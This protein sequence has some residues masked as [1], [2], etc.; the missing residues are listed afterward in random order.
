MA[1]ST[2]RRSL[3]TPW[4]LA[5]ALAVTAVVVVLGWSK[6]AVASAWEPS[7]TLEGGVG[8]DTWTGNAGVYWTLTAVRAPEGYYY[9][10]TVSE[11]V[12]TP[13]P[14]TGGG[15][16]LP[17]ITLR[18]SLPRGTVATIATIVVTVRFALGGGA[19]K[20][21]TAS[22]SVSLPFCPK[23]DRATVAFFM[24]CDRSVDVTITY[25][26]SG[27]V[28]TSAAVY[29]QS[30]SG[31]RWESGEL[32]LRAFGDVVT[33]RVPSPYTTRV[34]VTQV[35]GLI[36][37]ENAY[38]AHAWELAQPANCSSNPTSAP[39]PTTGG[40][41][42]GGPGGAAT[43]GGG[44]GGGTTGGG[45]SSIGPTGLPSTDGGSA[46]TSQA[47]PAVGASGAAGREAKRPSPPT[48]SPASVPMSLAAVAGVGALTGFGLAALCAA[49]LSGFV[50]V[51]SRARRNGV[52]HLPR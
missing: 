30:L 35:D 16:L 3:R 50:I 4:R 43:G 17:T 12:A 36:S 27:E 11:V 21:V 23:R 28:A 33:V 37:A 26:V 18:Q 14:A 32:P 19:Y 39:G 29:G 41:S 25:P 34:D 24:N 38:I 9:A 22:G 42:A 45:G 20:D 10:G 48:E 40:G 1:E 52:G 5:A 8:C 51:R 46:E 13:T 49:A 6:P 47:A 15:E 2:L 7:F 31:A 44:S